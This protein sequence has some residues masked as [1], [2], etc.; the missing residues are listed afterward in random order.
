MSGSGSGWNPFG[1]NQPPQDHD[2]FH[3]PFPAPFPAP[4]QYAFPAFVPYHP[5][6]SS[7]HGLPYA[8][9]FPPAQ[10]PPP[11]FIPPIHRPYPSQSQTIP[12]T[13]PQTRPHFYHLDVLHPEAIRADPTR[14]ITP[15]ARKYGISSVPFHRL[16]RSDGLAHSGLNSEFPSTLTPEKTDRIPKPDL[17]ELDRLFRTERE[18]FQLFNPCVKSW[19]IE[20]LN[21]GLIGGWPSAEDRSKS[22]WDQWETFKT[23]LC[24]VDES[25]WL[26]CFRKDRWFDSRHNAL[27][28]LREPIP[29]V[30]MWP[31]ETWYTVDNP[32]IWQYTSYAI[33][34]FSRVLRLLCE[35]QNEWLDALLFVRP[36]PI[37][38]NPNYDFPDQYR[39]FKTKL[40]PRPRE[41]RA[42]GA[43]IFQAIENLTRGHIVNTFCDETTLAQAAQAVTTR[44]N[45]SLLG[46]ATIMFNVR[47]ALRPLLEMETSVPERCM[48]M[49]NFS[50][51]MLHEF[52]HAMWMCQF[53]TPLL[54]DDEPFFGD[55]WIAELGHSFTRHIWGG[56][57]QPT[58]TRQF[59]RGRHRGFIS[60]HQLELFPSLDFAARERDYEKNTFESHKR[61]DQYSYHFLIP[62]VWASA[63]ICEEFWTK[64]IPR[65]GSVALRPPLLFGMGTFD[66]R[67]HESR[68]IRNP[69]FWTPE[70]RGYYESAM[71]RWVDAGARMRLARHDWYEEEYK[72]WK[73]LPWRDPWFIG[74][75]EQFTYHHANRNLATCREL[76][77]KIINVMSPPNGGQPTI[78]T[79]VNY[80]IGLVM[81]LSLPREPAGDLLR[82]VMPREAFYYPSRAAEPW[83]N[84][85]STRPFMG[86]HDVLTGVS[87]DV[88]Q[89][90]QEFTSFP[91]H[92]KYIKRILA[93]VEFEIGAPLGW[94]VSIIDNFTQLHVQRDANP[95]PDSWGG[96]SFKVPPYDPG[97]VKARASN[98]SFSRPAQLRYRAIVPW[99]LAA[100]PPPLYSPPNSPYLLPSE[101][102]G[103]NFRRFPGH[104]AQNT[105]VRREYPQ[106]FYIGD[107]AN[108]RA[109]DD[110][111]VVESDGDDGFDV[112]DITGELRSLGATETDYGAMI[113]IGPQGPELNQDARSDVV[114]AKFNTSIQPIG[115]LMLRRRIEEVA[116]C[117]GQ[118]GRRTWTSWGPLIF[119]ITNFPARSIEEQEA[120]TES[121]GGPL[122]K[123]LTRSEHE[124]N[125]LLERL[126]PYTCAY[127]HVEQ[128]V[129]NMRYFTPEMLRWYD[130]PSHGVYIA[131]E[132]AVYDISD[133][134]RFHPGGSQLLIHCTGLD[135]THQFLQYHKTDM[136]NSYQF[137]QV[138]Y[139]VPEC[140]WKQ[141]QDNHV[142]VHDWVFNISSLQQE[143]SNLFNSLHKFIRQDT[144]VAVTG[145][146]SD[147][148][149]LIKLFIDKQHLIVAG[150]ATKELLDIPVWEFLKHNNYEGVQGA[151][152]AVEGYIYNVEDL[153]KY[154][155][156]YDHKLGFNWAGKELS[157]PDLAQWLTTNYRSRCIGRLVEGPILPEPEMEPNLTLEDS[158]LPRGTEDLIIER[159]AGVY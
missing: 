62:A 70:L 126:T 123:D 93:Y 125:Q 90:H 81:L 144:T 92:I 96:F 47:Y 147:A 49:L 60:C 57:V 106:H 30:N 59:I 138:G 155:D 145:H 13:F 88:I 112:F 98:Q 26:S 53:D 118:N 4:Y 64:I 158:I 91:G 86:P 32:I 97:W 116:E 103:A 146:D 44:F 128:P 43:Q 54:V 50:S 142:V 16:N 137:M 65:R 89:A 18:Q 40:I 99:N 150:L 6:D 75:I 76:A 100:L 68:R 80:I 14:P 121:S 29:G 117:D 85:R 113:V 73:S 25:R 141:L 157:N 22:N 122:S 79:G 74:I 136:M 35:E 109:L 63:I 104:T 143:D 46:R 148:A 82:P 27:N 140:T 31:N 87:P 9:Q 115:K 132:N 24:V 36:I 156:Y 23:N 38:S 28:T 78:A 133:Y 15:L 72:K 5:N 34:I 153:M 11:N 152:V 69:E 114:R 2:P 107:V 41:Q 17:E 110:A 135:A 111:W 71:T 21:D 95:R 108:H 19:R 67:L 149:A 127:L 8:P 84:A 131:L 37:G 20:A 154:P 130:N 48:Q 3:D 139:L 12:P 134:L 94:I 55:E 10:F 52:A 159:R 33:E 56:T 1:P 66:A 7:S 102:G 45:S 129:R 151:W 83:F 105:P 101:W 51:L 124:T 77:L 61:G 42:S 120:L 58:P 39:P 119:D